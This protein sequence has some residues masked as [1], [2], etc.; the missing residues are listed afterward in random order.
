M[1]DSGEDTE[2]YAD[3]DG[4]EDTGKGQLQR[5]AHLIADH[6]HDR[7]PGEDGSPKVT[8]EDAPEELEILLVERLIE[9]ELDANLLH[10]LL[11]HAGAAAGNLLGGIA[12]QEVDHEEDQR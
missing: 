11:R 9:T 4:D 8:M 6:L 1:P 3:Q 12:G 7:L 5:A 10:R 2:G